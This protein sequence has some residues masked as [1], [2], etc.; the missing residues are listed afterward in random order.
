MYWRQTC[1]PGE[2]R[3]VL[4]EDRLVLETELST[5]RKTCC[6]EDRLVVL[7]TDLSYCKETDL[8]IGDSLVVL[9]IR[10]TCTIVLETD[11]S[12]WKNTCRTGDRVVA[13]ETDPS[14]IY[15]R[16]ICCVLDRLAVSGTDKYLRQ[17]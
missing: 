13:L 14:Y 6:T 1:Q 11:L 12:T 4:I 7:E 10:L 15:W 16:Q 17:T 3:V 9:E 5:W 2:R 8:R